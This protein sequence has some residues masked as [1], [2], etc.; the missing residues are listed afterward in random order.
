MVQMYL[1]TFLKEPFHG[2]PEQRAEITKNIP[3][4]QPISKKKKT[5][6]LTTISVNKMATILCF[7]NKLCFR[8][9][10]LLQR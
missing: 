9:R 2:Y 3:L 5:I 6:R 8:L 7:L 10:E 4:Q 1:G